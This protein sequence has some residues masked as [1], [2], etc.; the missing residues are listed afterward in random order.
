MTSTSFD[1]LPFFARS[2]QR[3][4]HTP[5]RVAHHAARWLVLIGVLS[6]AAVFKSGLQVPDINPD[7]GDR[8]F[9]RTNAAGCDLSDAWFDP[10]PDTAPEVCHVS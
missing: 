2:R 9:T 6:G 5:C 1:P 7:G 10:S 4:R 3:R 8:G